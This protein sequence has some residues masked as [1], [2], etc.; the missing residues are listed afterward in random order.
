MA[1]LIMGIAVAGMLSG[2][3]GSMRNAARL[4][5]YDRVAQ[6]A[7]LRMNELLLDYRLPRDVTVS[8]PFDASVSGGLQA[9]WR[10]RLSTFEMPPLPT[11]GGLALDRIEL[12]V[13]WMSGPQRRTFALDAYRRRLLT[14]ADLAPKAAE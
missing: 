10:T 6:L 4:A 13:W 1:T 7:R 12:E 11:P 5:D 3:S 8:G 9:G 14:A 2:I